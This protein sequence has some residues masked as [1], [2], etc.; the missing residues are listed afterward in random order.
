MLD[1]SDGSTKVLMLY[2]ITEIVCLRANATE[3]LTM[4]VG[5]TGEWII[6]AAAAEGMRI[7]G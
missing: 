2:P 6:A 3:Q 4:H 1:R 5:A 7:V